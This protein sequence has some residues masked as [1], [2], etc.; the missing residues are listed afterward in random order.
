MP[1][2]MRVISA[3][4]FAS[5]MSIALFFMSN[6]VP[7]SISEQIT[8]L[9]AKRLPSAYN[10]SP[11]SDIQVLCPG[12]KGELG[13]TELNKKL[14][15]VLN[16]PSD[17]KNE[18][19]MP[20]YVFRTGDKVM[21]TKNNYDLPWEKDDGSEGTGVFNGDIGIIESIDKAAKS[22][23][24][25]FDDRRVQ[26]NSD[27]LLNV[28]LA[29]AT[30]VHKSQGNEFDAVVMPVHYGPPQLYYRNLLYT[31]VTRAKK[32]LI[33]VGNVNVLKQMVDNNKRTAR[34]SGLRAFLERGGGNVS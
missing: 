18:I 26:Y 7:Y 19:R 24:I 20:V 16:P 14:Q 21:Q 2:F 8:E 27:N 1:S 12:R 28:E 25:R 17:E 4:F 9:C 3:R 11:V 22:A 31:A 30:T 6:T 10:F 32:I 33:I 5:A 13:V 29:Y 34:Y 23:V 15:Q